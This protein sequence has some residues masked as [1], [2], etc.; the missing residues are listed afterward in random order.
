MAEHEACWTGHALGAFCKLV[1]ALTP[2][3]CL[4]NW[5]TRPL[6]PHA[7]SC[8]ECVTKGHRNELGVQALLTVASFAGKI[9]GRLPRCLSL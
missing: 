6:P 9:V 8:P 7:A 3:A 1:T 2:T 5:A 4:L